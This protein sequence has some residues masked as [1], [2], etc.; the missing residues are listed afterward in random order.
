MF[1]HHVDG[2][3]RFLREAMLCYRVNIMLVVRNAVPSN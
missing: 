1:V 3:S 2:E